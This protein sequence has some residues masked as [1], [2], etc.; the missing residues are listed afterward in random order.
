M[1]KAE[2]L[3]LLQAGLGALPEG[4][5]T[6]VLS[7]YE[8][9]IEDRVEDGMDEEAAVAAM[10]DP[11]EAARAAILDAPL[12]AL[13]KN[14]IRTHERPSTLMTVL[15]CVGFPL[16]FPLCIAALCVIFSI[17]IVIWSVVAALWAVD[18]ALAASGLFVLFFTG[19]QGAG[20]V[21]ATVGTGLAAA[22]LS[23]LLFYALLAVTKG[24]IQLS[25]LVLRGIKK[26]FLHEET[27]K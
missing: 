13:V 16:W 8:E 6:K 15:L 1:T 20:G 25:R 12:S 27:A 11:K 22:G 19:F 9:A 10:D 4:E 14:R 5:R 3:T 2:Y 23:I 24:A 21:L 18:A 17:F 7:F 26:I